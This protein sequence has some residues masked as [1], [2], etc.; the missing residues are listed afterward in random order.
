MC[1]N[2]KPRPA[3]GPGIEPRHRAQASSQVLLQD[4]ADWGDWGDW[5]DWEYIT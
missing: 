1:R 3:L 4:W 5:G 2:K